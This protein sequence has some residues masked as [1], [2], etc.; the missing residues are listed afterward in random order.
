[1]LS[2]G[3]VEPGGGAPGAVSAYVVLSTSRGSRIFKVAGPTDKPNISELPSATTLDL[4][5]FQTELGDD[6]EPALH[7]I[8]SRGGNAAIT[9]PSK[10]WVCAIV[11]D[12]LKTAEGIEV[13]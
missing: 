7:D 3:I 13:G 2:G 1:M 8:R 9:T 6:L 12:H 10:D 5:R 11:R 4:G